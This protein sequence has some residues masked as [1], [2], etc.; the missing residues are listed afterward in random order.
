MN[1]FTNALTIAFL[2]STALLFSSTTAFAEYSQEQNEI[3]DSLDRSTNQQSQSNPTSNPDSHS[4]QDHDSSGS[5]TND[6]ESNQFGP[7]SIS[8]NKYAKKMMNMDVVN[9]SDEKIGTVKDF[10]L[11]NDNKI[12]YA[13]ISVGGLLGVGDKLIA[14]PFKSLR[15]NQNEEK[16]M[17]DA[18]KEKLEQAKEFQYK[19]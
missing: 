8:S 4:T 17:L 19:Q 14:V 9:N 5:S 11:S 10:A 2:I 6:S 16:I 3:N 12:E 15:V 7:A 18:T 13:I 1:Q